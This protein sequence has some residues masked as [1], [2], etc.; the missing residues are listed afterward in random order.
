[1]RTRIKI[2]CI[3]NED[4]AKL[5]VQAGADAVG[6][7]GKMPSG[8]GPIPDSRIREIAGTVPPPVG[9]F[10]LTSET[11]ASGVAEHLLRTGASTVQLVNHISL[12]ETMALD[13]V[14]L[15]TRRVQVIHVEGPEAIELIPKYEPHV[16]AFLLDSGRPS[17]ETPELGGTGRTHDWSVS[18]KFVKKSKRPVFLAGGLTAD[19]VG[20]AIEQVR[21]FGVDV[22]SGVRTEGKLDKDK[23]HAFV[24]AVRA[25]DAAAV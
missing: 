21:P 5:A 1:M 14:L 15:T 19:N 18:A 16:H 20:E 2:C 8:P 10:L 9:C 25:M 17:A 23:L 6:L 4:E 24:A 22:C 12:A 7:V 13:R 3:A 11:T